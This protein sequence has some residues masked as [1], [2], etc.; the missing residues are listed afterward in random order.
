MHLVKLMAL[1][2]LVGGATVAT[3]QDWPAWGGSSPGR[4]LYSP[5]KGLVNSFDPGKPKA[6][7]DEID[8]ATTRNVRCTAKLGSQTYANAVVADGRV[9]LGT[10]N[11]PPR[12]PR[13]EGDRSLLLCL[14]E[15][16][17]AELW[18][19]TVP[20]LAA[21]KNA[22]WENLGLLASPTV[23]GKRVYVMTT[24]CEILCLDTEGMA[25]GNDGPYKDEAA[26]SALDTG[27]PAV[28]PGPKDADI[29]WRFNLLDEIGVLPRNAANCGVLVLG[30][31]LFTGTANGH[32]WQRSNVPFPL[33]PSLIALDKNTGALVAADQLKNGSNI[34]QGQWS[35]PSAGEVKGRTLVFYSGGD[36]WC[37]AFNAQPVP[38]KDGTPLLEVVWK[39]DA[40]PPE[41]KTRDGQPIQ[42]PAAEGPSE[43]NATPV[44]HSNRVYVATGQDP[45]HG[46]G[47]GRLLCLDA[48]LTG[49]ISTKGVIWDYREIKRS[50]STVSIDPATGLLF[51]A[52]FSGYVHCLD[53]ASGKVQ[54]VYDMKGHVW[55]STLVA[56][57][58]VYVGDEDG[59]FV[60]LPAR[61]EFDP[62]KDKPLF[63]T[64]FG[65]P[66]YSTPVVANGT[67]YLSTMTHLYAIGEKLK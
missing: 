29:L 65:A 54:W 43:I 15:K 26:Y 50:L 31:L 30:N 25:N 8:A 27:K 48:T 36:G 61:R 18:H 41:Y 9:Y 14:D 49:D 28:P 53:A 17:G 56:E 57:G 39:A 19:L 51:A 16:T 52:D 47:I 40:N 24:R 59:D 63:E 20:K 2:A 67:I 34:F 33:A 37:Y 35:S 5:Q 4:N 45:E 44:F 3:G 60:I 42:Y 32:D 11:E 21:G 23:E 46:E 7:G 64:N 1:A 6:G 55:G 58:K 66:L 62:K 22:D 12:D 13:H 38:G 10:N